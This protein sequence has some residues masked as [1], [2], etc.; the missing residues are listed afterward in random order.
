ML[1]LRIM[2][3]RFILIV[4][5]AEVNMNAIANTIQSAQRIKTNLT[6]VALCS[7]T[8]QLTKDHSLIS[9]RVKNRAARLE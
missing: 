9:R 6:L 4:N 1:P 5:E 8:H 2:H 7:G 3:H